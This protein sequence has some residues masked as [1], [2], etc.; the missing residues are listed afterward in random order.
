MNLSVSYGPDFESSC[1]CMYKSM[2][3]NSIY[4]DIDCRDNWV[5]E[6]TKINLITK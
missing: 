6:N 3:Y 1:I 2:M 4:V 5:S